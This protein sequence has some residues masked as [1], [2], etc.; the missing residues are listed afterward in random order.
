MD[1]MIRLNAIQI[2][3]IDCFIKQNLD[4]EE[5]INRINL[6]NE[7]VGKKAMLESNYLYLCIRKKKLEKIK[8][9][10]G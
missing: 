5:I 4:Y 10:I 9:K 1:K 2:E 3:L 6:C 8:N 7:I